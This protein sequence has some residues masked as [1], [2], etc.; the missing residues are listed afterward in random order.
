MSPWDGEIAHWCWSGVRW[1]ITGRPCLQLAIHLF[2]LDTDKRSGQV[3]ELPND[4]IHST[5]G[6][7]QSS[8]V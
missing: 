3:F 4:V 5:A 1:P 2:Q 8:P 7:L 6:A